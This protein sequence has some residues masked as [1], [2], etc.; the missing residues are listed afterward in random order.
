MKCRAFISQSCDFLTNGGIVLVVFSHLC[1]LLDSNNSCVLHSSCSESPFCK[2]QWMGSNS[3]DGVGEKYPFNHSETSPNYMPYFTEPPIWNVFRPSADFK[4]IHT[5]VGY[6]SEI[7]DPSFRPLLQERSFE[8][9]CF[10]CMQVGSHKHG[11]TR[12][13]SPR[14]QGLWARNM[15]SF[16]PKICH[17]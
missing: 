9:I 3:R 12:Q 8:A 11:D 16:A 13:C 17:D 14:G 5:R 2:V 1:V 6:V 10:V 15:H 4:N 7:T